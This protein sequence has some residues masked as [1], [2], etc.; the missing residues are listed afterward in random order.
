MQEIT[1]DKPSAIRGQE[2]IDAVSGIKKT[3][4]N[5]IDDLVM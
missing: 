3:A 2:G 5:G 1:N 4:S